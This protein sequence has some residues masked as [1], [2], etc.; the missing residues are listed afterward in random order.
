MTTI[1]LPASITFE[2]VYWCG[3][4]SECHP[5][6]PQNTVLF[7]LELSIIKREDEDENSG[8]SIFYYAW[9]EEGNEIDWWPG[10]KRET[11]CQ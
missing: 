1:S 8:T 4:A 2:R 7:S 10:K 5:F 9:D 11:R 6:H 3:K